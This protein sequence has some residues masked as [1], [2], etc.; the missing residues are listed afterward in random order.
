MPDNIIILLIVLIIAVMLAMAG[1]LLVTNR[2]Q[3]Q[4]RVLSILSGKS[5]TQKE[6]STKDILDKR[7]AELAKKLQ[8][9][10]APKTKHQER[11]TK[12]HV[13]TLHHC[14][15]RNNSA[16]RDDDDAIPDD[17]IFSRG[18]LNA[19]VIE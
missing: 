14:P 6:D 9:N 17:V 2:K 7:R 13:P 12:H 16:F 1:V 5:F 19:F 15:I 3:N 10:E 8:E 11:S 18:F 4:K